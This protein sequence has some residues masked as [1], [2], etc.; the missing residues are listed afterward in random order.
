[1]AKLRVTLAAIRLEEAKAEAQ[2]EATRARQ[3]AR[4]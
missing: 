2:R 4:A 3:G 1:M